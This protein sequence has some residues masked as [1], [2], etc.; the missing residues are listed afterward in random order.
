MISKQCSIL[1]LNNVI[2][3][4]YF[5]DNFSLNSWNSNSEESYD[6]ESMSDISDDVLNGLLDD[7]SEDETS[8][9]VLQDGEDADDDDDDDDGNDDVAQEEEEND[10]DDEEEDEVVAAFIAASSERNRNHPPNLSVGNVLIGGFSFHPSANVI[11]LGLSSGDISMYVFLC[12]FF[13]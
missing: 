13:S 10:V 9:V 5:L 1:Y 3:F 4:I 11:A 8:D 7:L 2:M 12:I 6:D